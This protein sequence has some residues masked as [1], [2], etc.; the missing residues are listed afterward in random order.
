MTGVAQHSFTGEEFPLPPELELPV[1]GRGSSGRTVR[2]RV[3]P[4][5]GA[6]LEERTVAVALSDQLGAVLAGEGTPFRSREEL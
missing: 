4:R 3:S 1:L 2:A 5:A 6:S